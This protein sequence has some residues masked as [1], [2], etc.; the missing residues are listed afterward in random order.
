M[1]QSLVE[2]L[3]ETRING[4]SIKGNKTY[5]NM[6]KRVRTQEIIDFASNF[7]L[8]PYTMCGN[9]KLELIEEIRNKIDSER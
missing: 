5:E 1:K 3:V 6:L 4:N 7:D 2:I 8:H 9:T